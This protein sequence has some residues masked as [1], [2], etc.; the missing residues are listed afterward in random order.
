[1][2]NRKTDDIDMTTDVIIPAII[3]IGLF[4]INGIILY[5]IFRKRQ[6]V[7]YEE[8][9]EVMGQEGPTT[10]QPLQSSAATVEAGRLKSG[11]TMSE[12]E[13]GNDI[14]MERL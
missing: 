1:M 8:Y 14:E 13:D 5:F 11:R 10:S 6:T 7:V 3:V 4:L 12:N 9:H 2:E